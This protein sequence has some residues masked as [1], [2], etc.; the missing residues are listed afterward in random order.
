MQCNI[1]DNLGSS[2]ASYINNGKFFERPFVVPNEIV[3]K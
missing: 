2:L 3:D 1:S